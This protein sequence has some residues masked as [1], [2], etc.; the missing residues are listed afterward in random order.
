MRKLMILAVAM[1]L[2]IPVW[3]QH[4]HFS[5]HLNLLVPAHLDPATEARRAEWNSPLGRVR[6]QMAELQGSVGRGGMPHG[7]IQGLIGFKAQKGVPLRMITSALESG[8]QVSESSL[9]VI[10]WPWE[11]ENP[12]ASR[13]RVLP[14]DRQLSIL[15]GHRLTRRPPG[16]K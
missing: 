7:P 10:H 8:V 9:A 6:Y 16:S 2:A 3:A 1:I 4:P 12:K 11:K 5:L 14:L 15:L 13:T